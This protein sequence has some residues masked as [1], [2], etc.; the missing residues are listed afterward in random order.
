MK[1]KYPEKGVYIVIVCKPLLVIQYFISEL[2]SDKI[3]SVSLLD[4]QRIQLNIQVSPC[5]DTLIG[6]FIKHRNMRVL[7][8]RDI[9]LSSH[10]RAFSYL[11]SI[12]QPF[13]QLKI[14]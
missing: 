13:L 4:D 6:P 1:L 5:I 3:L 10:D 14:R 12:I 9:L 8:F 7:N 11:N 2:N